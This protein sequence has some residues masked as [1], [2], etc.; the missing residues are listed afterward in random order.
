MAGQ[1]VIGD[2]ADER[3]LQ[4]PHVARDPLGDQLEHAWILDCY[5][6]QRR[7]LPKDRDARG[8]IRRADVGHQ[9]G[10]EALAEALLDGD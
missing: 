3:T 4:G 9:A 7:A 6:I 1:G 10:L 8:E 5:V 2:H